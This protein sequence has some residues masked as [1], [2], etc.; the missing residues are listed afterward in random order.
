MIAGHWECTAN[1]G[2]VHF[3]MVKWEILYY[4]NLQLKYIYITFK[5]CVDMSVYTC[6]G[7]TPVDFDSVWGAVWTFV[8]LHGFLD[9]SD[10]YQ[11]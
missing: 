2:I 5:I 9:D 8:L 3:K 1:H 7:P 6:L 10:L 4:V 11:T